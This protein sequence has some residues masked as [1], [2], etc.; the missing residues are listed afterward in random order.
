[1]KAALAILVFLL[2]SSGIFA[3]QSQAEWPQPADLS[4]AADRLGLTCERVLQFPSTEWVE[5]FH[6]R[7]DK[8]RQGTLR[9]LAAYARCYD[10]RTNRLAETLARK[11]TGPLMGAAANFSQV[12]QRLVDFTA[13]A[14]AAAEPPADVVKSAFAGLYEKQFRY[15]FYLSYAHRQREPSPATQEEVQELA[16]AKHRLGEL[17]SAL[18][19]AKALEVH[20]AFGEIFSSIPVSDSIRLDAYRFA[21]FLL[22]PPSAPP[23]S[24]P[25]F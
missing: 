9:A 2:G 15:R 10:A 5:K 11:G 14:L 12:D 21:I 23:F 7:R 17:L 24:P 22:E 18:P 16:R 6:Q 19:D 4:A 1:M 8:S 3:A 25:P 20:A 13:E